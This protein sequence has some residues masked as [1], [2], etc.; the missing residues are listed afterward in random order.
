MPPICKAPGC[1]IG[2]SYVDS[3]NV[4]RWCAAHV[5]P[6]CEKVTLLTSKCACGTTASYGRPARPGETLD[7]QV[8]AR[9]CCQCRVPGDVAI[10]QGRE[11][12]ALAATAALAAQRMEEE[13]REQEE[14][15]EWILQ[16]EE[17]DALID[18]QAEYFALL[19]QQ[20]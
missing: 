20:Q 9:R 19:E 15:D 6:G 10:G 2:A 4:R 7:S 14:L 5:P 16:N 3:A 18:Q 8:R 11:R 12:R 17:M 1:T 13:L